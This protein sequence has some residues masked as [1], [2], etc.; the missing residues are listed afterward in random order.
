MRNK[1]KNRFWLVVVLMVSLVTAA[2]A[3]DLLPFTSN[4]ISGPHV[5]QQYCH[6]CNLA[7]HPTILVFARNVEAPSSRALLRDMQAL[8][9]KHS[10]LQAWVVF[11]S[12]PDAA[13]ETRVE[14]RARA[15]I[16]SLA[17]GRVLVSVLDDP[18]G[19]PGYELSS[20][21][22]ATVMV[23]RGRHLLSRK[24]FKP[25]RWNEAAIGTVLNHGMSLLAH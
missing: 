22:A 8:A 2:R 13:D 9:R 15:V 18:Q 1:Q 10:D 11:L 6:V 14:A 21:A 16:E 12:A 3:D 23:A 20:D 24:E 7:S 19:P 17:A 25:E 4:F 5:G